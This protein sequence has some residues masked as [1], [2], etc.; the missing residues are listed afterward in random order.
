MR[1][2]PADQRVGGADDRSQEV[3]Q[4][5]DQ[6]WHVRGIRRGLG[7]VWTL[8]DPRGYGKRVPSAR[9]ALAL[10]LAMLVLVHISAK[11]HAGD[12]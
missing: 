4:G 10:E 11:G 12:G 2:W 9:K 3:Q 5:A 7:H 1:T 6:M 8:H